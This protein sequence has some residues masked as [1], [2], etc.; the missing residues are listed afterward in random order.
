MGRLWPASKT[1]ANKEVWAAS[2]KQVQMYKDSRKQT[3]VQTRFKGRVRFDHRALWHAEG[4]RAGEPGRPHSDDV[5][6]L[7]EKLYD[8]LAKDIVNWQL[9]FDCDTRGR[10]G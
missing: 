7:S 3:Q 1:A 8:D 2:D 6:T 10:R 5:P 9:L 4:R